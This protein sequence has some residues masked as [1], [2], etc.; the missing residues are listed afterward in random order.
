MNVDAVLASR[1]TAC[2]AVQYPSRCLCASC[3]GDGFTSIPVEGEGTVLSYTD[4]YALA[5]DFEQRY[6]RLAIVELD[7]GVR[8]TGQLLLDAPSIGARVRATLG[9]VRIQGA[10]KRLGLQFVAA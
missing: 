3:G 4:L 2:G 6:L 1:C 9:V 8:A 10:T 7:S 5:I